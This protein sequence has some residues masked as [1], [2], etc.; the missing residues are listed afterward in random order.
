MIAIMVTLIYA[1][2]VVVLLKVLGFCAEDRD[3]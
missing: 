2:A 1:A 3:E